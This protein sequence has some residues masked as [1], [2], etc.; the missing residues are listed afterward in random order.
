MTNKSTVVSGLHQAISRNITQMR[1]TSQPVEGA[2]SRGYM[3]QTDDAGNW[4]E[5][6]TKGAAN[7]INPKGKD[8]QGSGTSSDTGGKAVALEVPPDKVQDAKRVLT[9]AGIIKPQGVTAEAI[10]RVVRET[11]Q[12][13]LRKSTNKKR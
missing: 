11:I 10:R 9:K 12:E 2:P 6:V 1:E 7:F 13:Q 8:T 3:P 5:L 4:I